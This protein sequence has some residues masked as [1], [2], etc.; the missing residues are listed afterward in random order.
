MCE[1]YKYLP[2]LIYIYMSLRKGTN[3]VGLGFIVNIF[4]LSILPWNRII[5]DAWRG[6]KNGPLSYKKNYTY[7][8]DSD[9]HQQTI[10]GQY[11]KLVESQ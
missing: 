3:V 9:R 10:C 1:M 5:K 11:T 2:P 8:I 4:M 7:W 6:W